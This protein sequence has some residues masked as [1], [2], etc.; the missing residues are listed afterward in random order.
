MNGNPFILRTLGTQQLLISDTYRMRDSAHTR[1][2]SQ[3]AFFALIHLIAIT[4]DPLIPWACFAPSLILI[5]FAKHIYVYIYTNPYTRFTSSDHI[6]SHLYTSYS[7]IYL[8][9]YSILVLFDTRV[10]KIQNL[11]SWWLKNFIHNLYVHTNF[12]INKK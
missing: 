12:N 10:Q 6:P 2:Y 5:H 7:F 11:K 3:C 4:V 1:G 8:I 9:A